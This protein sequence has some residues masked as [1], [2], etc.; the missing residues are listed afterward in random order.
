PDGDLGGNLRW[1]KE[2]GQPIRLHAFWDAL[3]GRGA[4]YAEIKSHAEILTR[5][6]F[7][8][9]KFAERLKSKEFVA[10]AKEGA[11]LAWEYAYRKGALP[12]LMMAS[13]QETAHKK[14]GAPQVPP[15]YTEQ[16]RALARQQIALAGH[17]LGDQLDLVFPRKKP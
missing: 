15:G 7:E 3:L 10:W 9:D 12:G 11:A 4:K 6:D 5:A 2:N 13:G 14:Q 17:R 16:A 1:V 8:R